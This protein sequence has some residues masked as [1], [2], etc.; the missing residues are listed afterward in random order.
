MFVIVP[1][2]SSNSLPAVAKVASTS[3]VSVPTASN[4]NLSAIL[5]VAAVLLTATLW[6]GFALL[7]MVCAVVPSKSTVLALRIKAPPLS[8]QFP[9]RVNVP[10]VALNVPP[11][12]VIPPVPMSH[13]CEGVPVT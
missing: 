8:V 7:V 6:K 10:E 4:S 9:A 5:T 3:I 13:A 12:I 2:L 11:S 1:P